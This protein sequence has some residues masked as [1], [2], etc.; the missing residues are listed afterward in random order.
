MK[1]TIIAFVAIL[2]L[3]QLIPLEKTNP[4]IDPQL[5]LNTDANVM[6][7]LKKS[8]F[9]CHSNE[10][11]WP[12]YASIAP[13]SFFVT[14]HVNDA[15][16]ALNFSNYNSIIPEIKERRLKR[17]IVTVKNESMALPS[18][19]FAHESAK[20]SKEEKEKLLAWLENEIKK[21]SSIKY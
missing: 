5:K 16:K 12:F 2:L 15:R 18:Y 19:R 1:K 4:P 21:F 6:E 7:I 9:D 17:A 11:N 14:S 10:T 13:F 8:C 20:L 3:F